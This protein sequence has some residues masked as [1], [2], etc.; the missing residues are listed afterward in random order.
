MRSLHLSYCCWQDHW[1]KF[2]F[3]DLPS[4]TY[5]YTVYVSVWI[6]WRIMISCDIYVHIYICSVKVGSSIPSGSVYYVQ[7]ISNLDSRWLV[8]IITLSS[9]TTSLT[10]FRIYHILYC[11]RYSTGNT[12]NLVITLQ[13]WNYKL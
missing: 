1:F 13:F 8:I 10:K 3:D 9:N 4:F 7:R 5:I 2:V 11:K 12:A 6:Q